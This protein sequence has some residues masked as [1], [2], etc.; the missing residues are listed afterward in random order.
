[1]AL[2][3]VSIEYPLFEVGYYNSTLGRKMTKK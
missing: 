1:M 3:L 2:T